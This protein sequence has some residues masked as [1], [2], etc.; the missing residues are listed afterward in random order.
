MDGFRASGLRGAPLGVVRKRHGSW[1]AGCNAKS[2][3]KQRTPLDARG[4]IKLLRNAS[5]SFRSDGVKS[6]SCWILNHVWH[7]VFA[8][9]A[10]S[11]KAFLVQ[12]SYGG[13][14]TTVVTVM[15]HPDSNCLGAIALPGLIYG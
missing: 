13:K 8:S 7:E 1:K 11:G 4:G 15:R 14:V 3:G 10:G 6:L 12:A 2:H 9:G 5:D